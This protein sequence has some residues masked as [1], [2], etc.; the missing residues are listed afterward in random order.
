MK[1]D[2]TL[3]LPAEELSCC[4]NNNI[5]A[6]M[7]KYVEQRYMQPIRLQDLADYVHLNVSY[8]SVLFKKSFGISFSRYLINIRMEKAKKLLHSKSLSVCQVGTLVGY[9]DISYFSKEFKK[10]FGVSPTE[11]KS[12]EQ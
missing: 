9:P 5:I 2:S 7:K 1:E 8:C 4:R 10:K 6:D 3:L 11:Y 12:R